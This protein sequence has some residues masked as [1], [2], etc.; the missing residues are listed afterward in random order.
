MVYHILIL[1]QLIFY[2]HICTYLYS[3]V[4]YYYKHLHRLYSSSIMGVTNTHILKIFLYPPN[5]PTAC[6]RDHFL[7]LRQTNK[8][9]LTLLAIKNAW[10]IFMGTL[11]F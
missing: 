7:L 5:P 1:Y 3:N 6:P 9:S 2:I 4:V 11:V 10:D 8:K